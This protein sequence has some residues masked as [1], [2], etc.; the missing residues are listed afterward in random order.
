[1]PSPREDWAA[2]LDRLLDGDRLA[3]VKWSRLVTGW[4]AGW[5]AYDFRDEWDDLVQE[6]LAAAIDSAHKGRIRDREATFSYVRKIAHN[7]FCRRLTHHIDRCEDGTVP[8]EEVSEGVDFENFPGVDSNLALEMR[9][10]LEQLPPPKGQLV[11]AVYGHKRTVEQA[12]EDT[13]VPLGTVKRY[14]RQALT[15]LRGNLGDDYG[16]S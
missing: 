6:I 10:A 11:L 13:G 14:L 8:W 3:F 1:M 7:K 2:V 12:A 4:L 15:Q 5:R 16:P 9:R